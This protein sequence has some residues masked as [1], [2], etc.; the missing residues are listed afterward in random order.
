MKDHVLG[1]LLA[2]MVLGLVAG[3]FVLPA[4]LWLGIVVVLLLPGIFVRLGRLSRPR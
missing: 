2:V 3:A 1:F 4:I